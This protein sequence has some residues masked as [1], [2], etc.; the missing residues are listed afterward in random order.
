MSVNR[1]I[2]TGDILRP[3]KIHEQWESATVKNIQWL[4]RLLSWQ[5]SKSTGLPQFSVLWNEGGFNTPDIYEKL[6]LPLNYNAWASLFYR[7]TFPSDVETLLVTP[8]KRALVVGFEIPDV[9][10]NILTR[11]NIP[12]VD[13][14]AHPIRFMQDLVFAFRTNHPD[15]HAALLGYRLS[16]DDYCTPYANL[17]Q[18]KVAWMPRLALPP[19]TALIAGQ[20]ATDKALICRKTGRFLTLA[21]FSEKL[22]QIEKNHSTILFKPHP[23][24]DADCPSRRAVEALKGVR[25]VSH[26]FYYLL[27]QDGLTDV[28]A[29]NSGTV[30]EAK[31]FGRT[32]NRLGEPLYPFGE[33]APTAG[34]TGEA[35][36][37][38]MQ[39]L[40]PAFWAD[41]LKSV[42]NVQKDLPPGPRV[43]PSLLRRSL[44]ADWDYSYIDEVVQR[45]I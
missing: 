33:L 36:A 22:A 20:V 32:G 13:I 21:D 42:T 14:I 41:I 45:D 29:I 3:F 10:Q 19:N 39:F 5:L 9:L 24:Q 38:G 23:Y 27:S 37:I 6:S 17:V 1:I 44:N 25:E 16:L 4:A 15:I 26:N 34:N 31:Y 35:M 40:E 12:F 43:R 28:Y 11:H 8:F 30:T 7:D 2:F 18:A